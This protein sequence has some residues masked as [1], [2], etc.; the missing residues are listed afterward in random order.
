MYEDS[1]PWQQWASSEQ[2]IGQNISVPKIQGFDIWATYNYDY[3]VLHRV[4]E[5]YSLRVTQAME[6]GVMTIS[7]VTTLNSC[8]FTVDK[9]KPKASSW[10][11][12]PQQPK[13][14]PSRA[15]GPP[16]VVPGS[17]SS[18]QRRCQSI[19][20]LKGLL[21][22]SNCRFEAVAVVLQHWMAKVCAWLL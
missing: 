17:A 19:Q 3:D 6:G 18:G 16:D 12:T 4:V 21:A 2:L 9:S 14:L 20:Q 8:S 22:A 1:L 15:N 7:V 10:Q 11:Q 5:Y 13:T